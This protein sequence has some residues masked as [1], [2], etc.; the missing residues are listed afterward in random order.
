MEIVERIGQASALVIPIFYNLRIVS[1]VDELLLAMMLGA[2]G[3]YY[4]GWVRYIVNGR[5]L[6][7]YYRKLWGLPLPMHILPVIYFLAASGLLHSIPLAIAAIL[8]G[9]GHIYMGQI[10]FKRF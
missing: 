7:W 2:L 4:A 9:I 3:L 6:S 10:E 1:I 5:D 8:F